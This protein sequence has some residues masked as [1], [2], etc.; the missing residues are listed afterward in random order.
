MILI[1]MVVLFAWN[2]A[3]ER[4][5]TGGP[6]D[7]E[8]PVVVYSNPLNESTDMDQNT[9][10]FI[11]FS[12]QME[13]TSVEGALQ[14]W[15]R[16]PGGYELKT[17]WTSVRVTFNEPLQADE[18]YL[19]TID[20]TAKDLRGNGLESTYVL[21]FS[22]GE[23][24]NRGKIRGRV[25]GNSVIQENGN[26]FLYREMGTTLTDL[27]ATPADYV[28]QTDNDGH[29]ELDYLNDQEYMLFYH[30]DR[31]RDKKINAGDY[32]G[33]PRSASVFARP[34]TLIKAQKIWPQE[35]PND[36]AKLLDVSMLADS[37]A[38]VR[39]DLF[40]RDETLDSIK[41]HT[42]EG[43][44]IIKGTSRVAGDDVA[45][46]L[47]LSD[48][49]PDGVDVWIS[50]LIDTSGSELRSDTLQFKYQSHADS[51]DLL[52]FTVTWNATK[53]VKYPSDPDEIIIQ[54][55]LPIAFLADTVFQVYEGLN[56][57]I[58]LR[59]KLEA[60]S[61]MQWLFS[62][63][64]EIGDGLTY[65]WQVQ[66]DL[67]QSD[68][69]YNN[70]DSLWTGNLQSINVDSLG[71]I[72]LIHMGFNVIECTLWGDDIQRE[73]QLHPG[74]AVIVE[75]LPA[76]SYRLVGYVDANGNGLYDSA[77]M[78]P[79]GGSEEFWVYP[80]PIKVRARWETD[81]GI[82]KLRAEDD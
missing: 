50:G 58:P 5:I 34:D 40:Y 4:A 12:E 56:D 79:A 73:F 24:M 71:S 45:I 25:F 59:G 17:N 64:D 49:L 63:V 70:L 30:W 47:S 42:S 19:L 61:T 15:P 74:T 78:S 33:R 44:A 32:F 2:C 31:D 52:P 51:L 16:P 26:L 77:T 75:D 11:R 57:S 53:Q 20:K 69:S 35:I 10:I 21:A 41:V 62:P 8:A 14:I 6:E 23:E 60:V 72:R 27:I 1:L 55:S 80:E 43:D 54:S 48:N 76:T 13:K 9:R 37:F 36:R 65:H 28:F 68:L 22:T 67:I 7:S 39:T 82:W 29:F 66:T 18:T 46:L 38:Q 3:S 81:I